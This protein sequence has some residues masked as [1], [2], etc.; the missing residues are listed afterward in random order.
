MVAFFA[1]G[2]KG[3]GLDFF[4]WKFMRKAVWMRRRTLVFSKNPLSL[5]MPSRLLFYF[6]FFCLNSY[7][8]QV[9]HIQMS[10][11][12]NT[13][14]NIRLAFYSNAQ[15]FDDEKPMFI[16]KVAKQELLKNNLR[17]TYKDL[18]PG[19]YGIA[20]L[21]DENTNDKMDYGWVL[22]KEGFGFSDYYH[23]GM[24]RPTFEKFDFVLRKEETKLVQIKVRYL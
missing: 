7:S 19:V 12:R 22:P 3:T 8:A 2:G 14:G 5:G 13:S 20:I 16:R 6:L 24:T 15:S 21:D 4:G 11:L 1:A 18:A 9:L 17:I 23:S 10:G